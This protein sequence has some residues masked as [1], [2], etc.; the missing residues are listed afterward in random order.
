M[1]EYEAYQDRKSQDYEALCK[2]CGA[3]CGALDKDPCEHLKLA[4]DETYICDIYEYRFGLRT[5][6]GGKKFLCMPIRRILFKTWSGS[7]FCAYKKNP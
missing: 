7:E 4:G 2:R 5:T 1:S 3:C 6:V